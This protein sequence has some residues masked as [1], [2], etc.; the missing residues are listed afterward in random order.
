[1]GWTLLLVD[2]DGVSLEESQAGLDDELAEY[3]AGLD[4]F[5]ALQAL[6]DLPREEDTPLSEEA[7]EALAREVAELAARAKRRELPAPPDWVGLDGT[8]DLRLGEPLG[9][10]GLLDFLQRLEHLLFLGRRM[11]LGLW[12]AGEE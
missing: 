12:A 11:G 9:W 7:R 4:G 5:P 6:R 8:G 10:P 1:M 3:L 2:E